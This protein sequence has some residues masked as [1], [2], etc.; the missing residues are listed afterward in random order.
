MA[1]ASR[2]RAPGRMPGTRAPAA[3]TSLSPVSST[4][5]RD[6][7]L[8]AAGP[9]EAAAPAGARGTGVAAAPPGAAAALV[10]RST[11][12]SSTTRTF[13][14]ALGQFYLRKVYDRLQA[15]SP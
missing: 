6:R 9:A 3:S 10:T 7:P 8:P 15:T 5:V 1:P 2:S 13:R 14:D 11:R 12:R 4:I